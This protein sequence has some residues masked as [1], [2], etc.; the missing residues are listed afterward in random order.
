MAPAARTAAPEVSRDPAAPSH[1]LQPPAC[2][3]AGRVVAAAVISS[4]LFGYS[5]CVL[6]SCGELIAVAFEWCDNDWQSGCIASRGS[7]GLVNASLYLG[8]AIGALMSGR[9]WLQPLGSRTQIIISDAYFALGAFVCALAQGVG[10]LI[11]GRFAS[12]VGLGISAIAAPLYIAEI[13]PRERRGSNCAMHGVFIT[14][15]ILA[16]IAFGIPQGPPP[17]GPEDPLAGLDMWYWRCLLAFP[18]GLA[19]LQALLLILAYPIDPPSLLVQRSQLQRARTILYEIYGQRPADA[20]DMND[21]AQAALELQLKD[22]REAVAMARTVPRIWVV[23]AMCD[24]FLR[25]AVFLGVGLA[26]FQQ[27]CGI[28]GLMAYSN[29]LFAQAGISPAMLTLASTMMACANVAASVFSSRIVDYWGRRSLLLMGSFCQTLAMALLTLCLDN[30][31]NIFL[32]PA[33]VG[34]IAVVC[35]TVFVMSFSFG[36]GAIT[37]MYLSE[38]YPIEI[39]GPSLS[40][41]GVINW[42][43]SFVVVFGTRFLSLQGACHVFGMVC[44][45]GFL[46]TYA[47]VVETKGCSMDDSPLTPK[48]GRSQSP[49]L[50]PNTPNSPRVGYSRMEE[51]EEDGDSEDGRDTKGE[52]TLHVTE[53]TRLG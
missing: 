21:K 27:L 37:W 43:S 6:N 44:F 31:T 20:L 39:R 18:V 17:Q 4:F 28:N 10:T 22:L 5:I 30:R 51:E 26:A 12:G 3:L 41:C 35:F 2:G 36:L 38:I 53:G 33:S 29:S 34:P 32:P 25:T 13:S 11:V 49:L 1:T 14:L 42:L 23:Q 19:V 7:Q 46:C 8:A 45:F 52:F 9:S 16:S 40:A 15:G 50:T 24:P 47:W 48:T